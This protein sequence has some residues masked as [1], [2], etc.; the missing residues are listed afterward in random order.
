M[1]YNDKQHPPRYVYVI[2]SYRA[3]Q[4]H[5]EYW[6]LALKVA[7]PKVGPAKPKTKLMPIMSEDR[8]KIERVFNALADLSD[9]PRRFRL[10][11]GIYKVVYL[12]DPRRSKYI[13]NGISPLR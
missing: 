4:S 13:S 12:W 10:T 8:A 7:A 2:F 9:D 11:H 5:V 1:G 6:R 3:D